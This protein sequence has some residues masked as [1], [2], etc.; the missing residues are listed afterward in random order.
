MKKVLDVLALL[1]LA[2]AVSVWADESF[3]LSLQAAPVIVIPFGPD[4]ASGDALFGPGWGCELSAGVGIPK[5]T[6]LFGAGELG[7]DTVSATK[8]DERLSLLRF[9]LG[10]EYAFSLSRVTATIGGHGGYYAGFYGSTSSGNLFYDG[11][12]SFRFN[13]TPAFGLKLEGG[14]RDY[15]SLDGASASEPFLL[16]AAYAGIG[17]TLDPEGL[18]AKSRLV[19]QDVSIAPIFPILMKYYAT[20]PLGRFTLV[21]SEKSDIKNVEVSFFVP[22]YMDRPSVCAQL[23]LI[24]KGDKVT[25]DLVGLF[26]PKILS[27]TEGTLAQVEILVE[28]RVEQ[29]SAKMTKTVEA[30]I[31]DRN[32]LTWDDDRKAAAF[33]TTKDP[34][35]LTFAKN[36]VAT[37][38]A[39]KGI[40]IDGRIKTALSLF[41]AVAA[42]G[43]QYAP[44]P[45]SPYNS[46]DRTGAAVDFIQFPAQ[47]LQ[48][49]AG[50]CDD[51]TV[52][53]AT[54]LEAVGIDSAL[55]TTPGHIF[56]A[57]ALDMTPAS[58]ASL[59]YTETDY[60]VQDG[61]VW[62][63]VEITLFKKGFTQAW[64]Q[65]LTEYNSA[66]ATGEASFYPV[67]ACW[68]AYEPV[69]LVDA[70]PVPTLP[71][72]AILEAA[73][74]KEYGKLVNA[75]LSRK[76][77]EYND[78]IKGA[79][80]GFERAKLQN[81]LGVLYARLGLDDKAIQ[82][83]QKAKDAGSI[84]AE[85]NIGNMQL[86]QEKYRDATVTYQGA[87]KKDKSS[88]SALFGLAQSAAMDS[89]FNVSEAAYSA[90]KALD[91]NL[92][93]KVSGVVKGD[94]ARAADASSID[95][96]WEE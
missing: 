25:I 40:D 24:K 31:L 46:V 41:E 74:A 44:D 88:A 12:V 94:S 76:E 23:P 26:N 56:A 43:V 4:D 1:I 84:A 80:S 2:S 47:T 14:W 27:I 5:V 60:V 72:K 67:R 69:G 36:I 39:T 87:L 62:M 83:F 42:Y 8:P 7:F 32:A 9:G 16:R 19:A 90:L 21:N 17:A 63:P 18:R 93:A 48:Y 86:R 96:V 64:R 3:D 89:Q 13:L 81:K 55:I 15:L 65:A 22:A 75:I 73:F 50:D 91:G 61:K 6:G 78:R 51:L 30:K 58:A 57:F 11:G 66:F 54:L 45:T 70:T 68:D 37:A 35:I 92:A 49:R 52:L 10:A 20:N 85:I 82:Q 38:E 28:Y 79:P 34:S 59:F 53:Y 29:R 95:T 71:A 77:S 33:I